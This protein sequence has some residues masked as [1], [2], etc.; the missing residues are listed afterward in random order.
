MYSTVNV[1]KIRPLTE[2]VQALADISRSA[3]CCH[4]NETRAPIANLPNNAQPQGTPYH[5]PKLHP[6]PWSS[7]G[8]RRGTDRHTHK[9]SVINVHFASSTTH[10]KCNDSI[11]ER[12]RP[13]IAMNWWH[14]YKGYVLATFWEILLTGTDI[15]EITNYKYLVTSLHRAG[16]DCSQRAVT[17]VP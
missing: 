1:C 14:Y 7:V 15:D 16:Y 6:G 17:I 11:H 8:L 5:S 2:R 9:T 12:W 10:A 3:L 13:T 4:S